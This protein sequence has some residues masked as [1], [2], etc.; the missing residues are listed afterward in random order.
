MTK[1]NVC[2]D[3]DRRRWIANREWHT[4]AFPT[5]DLAFRYAYLHAVAAIHEVP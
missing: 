2:Y 3:W 1:W 4:M 5:W